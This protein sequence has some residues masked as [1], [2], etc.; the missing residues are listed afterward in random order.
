VVF[1][2]T[3]LVLD[4]A[5][6]LAVELGFFFAALAFDL[7]LL[8]A[9]LALALEAFF[10][11]VFL[12][13]DVF[14]LLEVLALFT[15]FDVFAVVDFRELLLDFLAAFDFPG[16]ARQ[17]AFVLL[18]FL[19]TEDFRQVHSELF[20]EQAE[21]DNPEHWLCALATPL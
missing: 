1:F 18:P 19:L 9:F 12:A 11:A 6:F 13:L 14:A 2:F 16:S 10:E 4:F 15:A 7:D 17:C 8:E 20:D 5:F 21:L 3:L